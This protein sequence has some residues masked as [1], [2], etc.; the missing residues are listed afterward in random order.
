MTALAATSPD[1]W[2]W[3]PHPEVWMLVA[4]VVGLAF[5]AV[6]VLGPKV[7]PAGTK[8]TTGRQ[9]MFFVLGVLLLWIA[10]DWPIHDIGE[11][12]L[13][14]VHMVQHLL[15]T[16]VVPPLFLLATPT[17]LA[18]SLLG[19]GAL[20]RVVRQLSRPVLAGLLFAGSVLITHAPFIVTLSIDYGAFH[21]L[22]HFVIV[23]VSFF[24]WMPV[25]GPIPEWRI[26]QPAQMLYLFIISIL[27]TVPAGWLTFAEA[28][29]YK[30]Y[31][32]AYRLWGISVI[33]DQQFA[34]F[35]M[36]V[37]GGVIL[38]TVI[39]TIF[40][41]WAAQHEEAE[42]RERLGEPASDEVLTWDEVRDEL[43]RLGPAPTEQTEP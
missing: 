1:A 36:K 38:W 27:P 39:A 21:Y 33:D 32:H 25:C 35:I 34:G 15:L 16:L 29:V 31:D 8:L 22:V 5:Y 24:M 37:G 14:S 19:E 42:R 20:L 7:V 9:R 11:E 3:Q 17:W 26:S 6:R 10:S 41:R 28:P 43:D 2:R 30:V 18:R 4:S 13:Y 23:T 40:F 12:Y